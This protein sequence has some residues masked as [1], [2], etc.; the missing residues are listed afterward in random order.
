MKDLYQHPIIITTIRH[1]T[2]E[3]NGESGDYQRSFKHYSS[4]PSF[5][6]YLFCKNSLLDKPRSKRFKS[7][8]KNEKKLLRLQNQATLRSYKTSQK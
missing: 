7:L 4:R 3:S 8:T 6:S 2:Y 1:E 5:L